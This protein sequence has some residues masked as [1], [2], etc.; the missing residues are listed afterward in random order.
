M[1]GLLFDK[2]GNYQIIFVISAALAVIAMIS[3]LALKEKRHVS[4]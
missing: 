2:T 3:T 4:Q 1:G